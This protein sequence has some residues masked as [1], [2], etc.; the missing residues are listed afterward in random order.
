MQNS[1]CR[2][3]CFL[4]TSRWWWPGWY[5]DVRNWVVMPCPVHFIAKRPLH[6][7]LTFLSQKLLQFRAKYFPILGW[8]LM[9]SRKCA[10][11][12]SPLQSK[13]CCIIVYL[14][15]LTFFFIILLL[16]CNC[17]VTKGW[18]SSVA[19]SPSWTTSAHPPTNLSN[20]KSVS[21]TFGFTSF[22]T[23]LTQNVN[24]F[25]LLLAGQSGWSELILRQM[26]PWQNSLATLVVFVEEIT[27][28]AKHS[29]FCYVLIKLNKMTTI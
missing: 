3:T 20:T 23:Y 1:Y 21:V 4:P 13:M 6:Y 15:V 8:I 2:H 19:W 25:C 12:L 5:I 27:L 29:T 16:Y 17:S 26:V 22:T 28:S 11:V 9:K 10:V 24:A 7:T 14:F 18:I